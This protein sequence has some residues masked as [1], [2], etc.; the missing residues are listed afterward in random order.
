VLGFY[1]RL[2]DMGSPQSEIEWANRFTGLYVNTTSPSV[3]LVRV[4]LSKCETI[5]ASRIVGYQWG[6]G[7]SETTFFQCDSR[8]ATQEHFTIPVLFP[9]RRGSD[10]S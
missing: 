9:L 2:E 4:E 1:L 7:G 3:G 10:A 6:R 8:V 5:P